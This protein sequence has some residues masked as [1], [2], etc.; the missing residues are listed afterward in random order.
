MS[1]RNVLGF[2]G[3]GLIAGVLGYVAHAARAGGIPSPNAMAYTGV[4]TNASGTPVPNQGVTLSIWNVASGGASAV[5]GPYPA[6]TTASDG[7]F[8]VPLDAACVTVVHATPNLWTQIQVAGQAS[9]MPRTQIGAVPYAVE[10]ARTVV[11]VDGGLYSVGATY[12]GSTAPQTGNL[13]AAV[14]GA[15]NGYAAGKSLCQTACSSPSA[16][17]C[18]ADDLIRSMAMG[19][20]V[21]DTTTFSWYSTAAVSNGTDF[22]ADC[23][24]WEGISG[25]GASWGMSSAARNFGLYDGN[26]ASTQPV[27]CCD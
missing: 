8:K 19:V 5:C 13:L 15:A 17:M 4:L 21:P 1:K 20:A 12:C 2:A 18:A 16:H 14:P 9:P 7:S 23:S 3:F 24:G 26:C 11:A 6:V 25:G 27:L 10:A 22:A